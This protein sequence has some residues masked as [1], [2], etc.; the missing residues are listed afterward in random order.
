MSNLDE[1]PEEEM[2]TQSRSEDPNVRADALLDL[3][4]R[5]RSRQDWKIAKNLYGSALDLFIGLEKDSEIGR[6]N[7]SY[8]Y[9]L[10]SLGEYEEA[11]DVLQTALDRGLTAH[12]PVIIGYSAG[13]LGDS[14]SALLRYEEA[15]EAYQ[16]AVDAFDEAEE[17]SQAGIN[18]LAMGDLLG[19]MGKQSRALECFIRAFNLFQRDGDSFGAAR[20]KERMAAALIELGDFDQAIMHLQDSLNVFKFLEVED[21]IAYTQYRLGW[22]LNYA[23]KFLQ[24]EKPLRDAI[25]YFR[26]NEDYSRAALAEAQLAVSLIYRDHEDV[27]EEAEGMLD[28]VAAY[29][30]AAGEQINVIVVESVVADRLMIAGLWADAEALWRDL[31]A[32]TIVYEDDKG[33]NTARLNLA[34]CLLELGNL[35]EA[36]ATFAE[37]DPN[38]WGEN[39]PEL[40]RIERVRHLIHEVANQSLF[41]T[42][43]RKNRKEEPVA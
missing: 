32:R 33:A 35:E 16:L 25:A 28:R 26:S 3:A 34:E 22:T 21:R 10:Y 38:L 14:L 24:A 23:E 17:E 5:A 29:F 37:V 27:P 42:G 19:V 40:E 9:C 4:H 2:W 11:R 18:A 43:P 7:Y 1:V 39:K 36:N 13:P 30:E 20:A 31:L 41:K 8:G 6:A 12:D 15:I